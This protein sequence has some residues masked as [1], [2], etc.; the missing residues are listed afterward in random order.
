MQRVCESGHACN[1][2][3]ALRE[4]SWGFGSAPELTSHQL[5]CAWLGERERVC[6]SSAG[7]SS[8]PGAAFPLRRAERRPRAQVRGVT[9]A[10]LKPRRIKRIAVLGGG[11]MGSGIATAS[12]LAGVEVLLKE[13][14]DKFLQARTLTLP[15]PAAC[16][17][18]PRPGLS[19]CHKWR[20]RRQGPHT[21]RRIAQLLESAGSAAHAVLV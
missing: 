2:L 1:C 17:L 19:C 20:G 18:A 8:P 11:L 21:A 9:D 12:V 3:E 13:I 7:S 16:P 4:C 5:L 6:N 15:W 14:N 10:G